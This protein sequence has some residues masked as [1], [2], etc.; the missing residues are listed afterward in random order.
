MAGINNN[1]CIGRV[2]SSVRLSHYDSLSLFVLSSFE[3]F[4]IEVSRQFLA[5][6][7]WFPGGILGFRAI[8]RVA[9]N[10]KLYNFPT[11]DTEYFVD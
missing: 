8:L 11:I 3:R 9:P 4:E 5:P 2:L 7:L 6:H 1:A 10:H